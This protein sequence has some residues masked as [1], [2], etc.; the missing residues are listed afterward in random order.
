MAEKINKYLDL[1]G[2]GQFLEKLDSRYVDKTT[3]QEIDGIKI[4]LE[5]PQS[6]DEYTKIEY[7]DSSNAT[8]TSF[9]Y[10]RTGVKRGVTYTTSQILS[11]VLD[12]YFTA[13]QTLAFCGYDS[14]GQLGQSSGKWSTESGTSNVSALTRTT[15]TQVFNVPSSYDRLYVNGTQIAN[16]AVNSAGTYA[17]AADYP[18]FVAYNGTAFVYKPAKLRMYSFK[19]YIGDASQ[20][21]S[22]CTLIRDFIPV[23]DSH[24]TVGLFDLVENKFY[25]SANNISFNG[26][27]ELSP[28]QT[29]EMTSQLLTSG[30]VSKVGLTNNYNDLD[31]KP[32]I[33]TVSNATIT[34]KQTG[35]SDQTF[36]LN[37]SAKTIT[38]VDTTYS[39]ATTSTSGL[40]SAADKTKLN[41][42]AT[43]AEVNVQS[44]W[45]VTDSTSDAYIK[46]KP[47]IPAAQVNSDWN[48]TSGVAEIL[49]KPTLGTAA[50]KNFTTSVTSDSSDLVTSGAVYS[51]IDNLPEPMVFKGTLGTGGTIT[52]LPTASSSNEGYT[53]KVITAGTYAGQVAK[54]GDVF[55]SNGSEWVYIPSGDDIEDTWRNIKVNGTELLGSA[56]STGAV[57]FKNGSN[58][59]ITGSGNDITISSSHQSI[60]TL[61]TDNTTAQST[62]SSEAIAGS[63]T[64]NLHKVAK[65][66]TYSD[67]IGTPTIPTSFNI[68]ANATDGIFDITGTGGANSVTYSLAPYSSST[69][70]DTWVE[71]S[72]NAGKFYLGTIDPVCTTR[73]NY[74]GNLAVSL[75]RSRNGITIPQMEAMGDASVTLHQGG[76]IFAT[77]NGLDMMTYKSDGIER[78]ETAGSTTNQ[79]NYSLPAATGTI[80]LTSDLPQVKRYI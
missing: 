70:T 44:D 18:L 28:T 55:T 8:D 10:I 61:K 9:P 66:G 52:T 11:C 56:I 19:M 47:T 14:G 43:G 21:T 72:S 27:E 62:S 77:N 5:R 60:K 32:T 49:N 46:N 3:D 23:K 58:V 71:N 38:L 51:A 12:G 1:T 16:R 24:G 34:I 26:G 13:S 45:N 4:F 54:E 7:I 63:G 78:V 42:I 50:A 30:D 25:T 41:G 64:I 31:N 6:M 80:A 48:A 22:G 65:T 2:L 75:L 69:A 57:N 74:N 68:T 33:P 59:T 67:L 20:S 17:T 76:L 15:V 39:E 29:I 37:G 73:L 79:Y 40:M 35:I 53:Y 36:T